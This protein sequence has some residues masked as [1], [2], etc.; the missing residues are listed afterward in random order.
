MGS[1]V[2]QDVLIDTTFLIDLQRSQRN[3]QRQQVESWLKEHSNLII[4]IPSIV[5][6]EYGVGF[7]TETSNEITRLYKNHQILSVGVEESLIYSR[8]YRRLKKDGNLI[9]SNDLWIAACALA[10]QIPLV[11]RNLSHFQ[12]IQGLK[13]LGY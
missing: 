2:M 11:S 1:R 3:P 6:G 9:A 13:L 5:L 12:R 7:Q 8:I 10:N 4:N